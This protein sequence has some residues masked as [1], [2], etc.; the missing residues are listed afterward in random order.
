MVC[1]THRIKEMRPVFASVGGVAS[2]EQVGTVTGEVVGK[3]R[4]GGYMIG[5]GTDCPC[6]SPAARW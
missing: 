1:T 5:G 6:F 3:I 2:T 4:R